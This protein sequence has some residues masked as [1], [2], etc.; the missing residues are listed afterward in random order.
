[1]SGR[2][3][4]SYLTKLAQC[5]LLTKIQ[6]GR[7]DTPSTGNRVR[8]MAGDQDSAR[9][10]FLLFLFSGASFIF[11]FVFYFLVRLFAV[12]VS[13][14]FFLF[15]VVIP[16]DIADGRFCDVKGHPIAYVKEEK[17]VFFLL[18]LYCIIY[19]CVQYI[20]YNCIFRYKLSEIYCSFGIGDEWELGERVI[21]EYIYR[22]LRIQVFFVCKEN[23]QLLIILGPILIR[24][25]VQR[26]RQRTE[27]SR[28][29][30]RQYVQQGGSIFQNLKLQCVVVAK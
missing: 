1:M 11:R 17:S 24:E 9:C 18:L 13:Q 4:T 6:P 30:L 23:M 7:S 2:G 29:N 22:Y 27:Y 19:M 15:H 12:L 26:K 14:L 3:A 28:E 25:Y 21:Y 16:Q 20:C 10:A 5:E 8:H